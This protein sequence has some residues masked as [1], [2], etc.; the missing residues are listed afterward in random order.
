M[1]SD[2]FPK[3]KSQWNT[4]RN[5]FKKNLSRWKMESRHVHTH[6]LY[7]KPLNGGF[8]I[9]LISFSSLLAS[10]F[11]KVVWSYQSILPI[12]QDVHERRKQQ[13]LNHLMFSMTRTK[14]LLALKFT[15]EK[16]MPK[17]W[18]KNH[19]HLFCSYSCPVLQC[20]T[21]V[22]LACSIAPTR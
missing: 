11:W 12:K 15:A 17:N 19:T 7:L 16:I 2:E 5:F 22:Y 21:K 4:W 13:K 18:K 6:Y 14:F 9:S 1:F 3:F 10:I 20:I 8:I